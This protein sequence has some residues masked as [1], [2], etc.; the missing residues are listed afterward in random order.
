MLAGVSPSWYTYLE[1]GRDIHPSAQVLD[2][3]ARVLRLSEDEWRYLR[4]LAHGGAAPAH[5]LVGEETPK[6]L[7]AGLV[8]TTED[9]P[10]PVYGVDVYCDLV[11]WN[12][13]AAGYYADFGRLPERD[14][15][16]LRCLLH[17]PQA[18]Q[19]L[20][21]WQQDARDVVARWRA[22]TASYQGDPRLRALVDE[23]R[24]SS[25]DFDRWWGEHDVQEH[26]SRLRRFR[27]PQ[28]GAQSLRLVVVRAPEFAPCLVVFH[29]PVDDAG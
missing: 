11:A 22:T 15:N 16:M 4:A 2:S 3:L 12:R 23:L 26:R 21:D 27:H 28:H 20:P 8:R 6:Q 19:R 5:P 13:A 24:Q 29:L 9:S 18:R 25:P 14:R 7:V 1:Q 10:Y 17:A